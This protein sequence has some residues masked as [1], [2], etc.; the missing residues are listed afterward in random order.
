MMQVKRVLLRVLFFALLGLLMEVFFGAFGALMRHRW[1]AVGHTSLWMLIDYGLAGVLIMPIG[2][3]LIR[4]G[5]PLVLRAVVYMLGIFAVEY[6]SG[7]IFT[8]M[9]LR[10]WGYEHLAYNLHGQ[11]APQFIPAWYSLGLV[12]EW[13]YRRI[14]AAAV[15]WAKKITVEQLLAWEPAEAGA[16]ADE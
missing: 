10:V 7:R 12:F 4:R 11:I 13:L 8:G 9:G 14:D 5:V 16:S 3:P 6:V 1:N 15:L 2:Q